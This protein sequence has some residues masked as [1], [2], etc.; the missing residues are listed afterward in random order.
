MKKRY[1]L[2]IFGLILVGVTFYIFYGV[3][4]PFMIKYGHTSFISLPFIGK[5]LIWC[6]IT[7]AGF[8]LVFVGLGEYQNKYTGSRMFKGILY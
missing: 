8:E 4:V 3:F 1:P 7:A 5:A 6:L 2:L